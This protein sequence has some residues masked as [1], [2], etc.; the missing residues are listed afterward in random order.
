MWE[1]LRSEKIVGDD[2]VINKLELVNNFLD[3][4][5][6]EEVQLTDRESLLNFLKTRVESRAGVY[7]IYNDNEVFHI[8]ES[9]DLRK[10]I[11]D[12]FYG[13]RDRKTGI[14]KFPRLF[15]AFL[16][17]EYG[18]QEKQYNNLS[19]SEKV[20]LVESYL[21]FI[22]SSSNRLRVCFTGDDIRAYVLEQTL[23]KYFKRQGQCK[24]DFQI[25]K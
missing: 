22:F 12:Q 3:E 15:Y 24:Y 1:N 9:E 13:T 6:C 5:Y 21:N 7:C 8:G 16:K 25:S 20:K 23:A 18:V 11:R 4:R 10:R 19:H 17:K 2:A 14:L